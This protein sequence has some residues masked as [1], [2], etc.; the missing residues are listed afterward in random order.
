MRDRL[1]Q[2]K[3]AFIH[4]GMMRHWRD[5]TYNCVILFGPSQD[6]RLESQQSDGKVRDG[7]ARLTTLHSEEAI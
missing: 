3:M 1:L 2:K 4:D 7:K 6:I 5:D